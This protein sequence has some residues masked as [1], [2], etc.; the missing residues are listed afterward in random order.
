MDPGHRVQ[1]HDLDYMQCGGMNANWWAPIAGAV[2]AKH[3]LNDRV[4]LPARFLLWGAAGAAT[5]V[6]QNG[7]SEF[8]TS[9]GQRQLAQCFVGGVIGGVIVQHM[10]R[11]GIARNIVGWDAP[12]PSGIPVIGK[13]IDPSP[14]KFG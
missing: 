2:V 9:E 14:A 1:R 12:R 5:D 8:S 13:L 3:S 7:W 11:R 6:Y 10:R 4:Q